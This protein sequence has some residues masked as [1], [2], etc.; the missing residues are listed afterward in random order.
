M[1]TTKFTIT[2]G[3]RGYNFNVPTKDFLA[4]LNDDIK[5]INP[6]NGNIEIPQFINL[7][8]KKCY[9]HF[10]LMQEFEKAKEENERLKS[11][12]QNLRN[13]LVDILNILN[14]KGKADEESL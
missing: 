5:K 13:E 4:Y 9:S 12:L 2:L 6:S 8:L 14:H 10:Q 1:E 7:Y 11:E 3:A